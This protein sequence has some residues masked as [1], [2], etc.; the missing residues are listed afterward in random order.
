M[1]DL[2]EE[3]YNDELFEE[4]D[5]SK[6]EDIDVSY[7]QNRDITE[8]CL[9]KTSTT[10][11]GVEVCS[12]CG[13]EIYKELSLEPEWRYYGDNDS[14]HSSDPSR[15]HIR[16]NDDK[17]IYQDI[18]AYNFPPDIATEINDNYKLVTSGQ[19]RRGNYRK[20]IIFAAAFNVYKDRNIAQDPEE[21]REKF[22]ITKKEAS[23]GLN[24]YNLNNKNRKKP[25]YI[26]P[27]SF[28]PRIMEKFKA[29]DNHIASVTDLYNKIYNRSKLL[30]RS[31][32]QSVIAG[33]VFYYIRLIGATIPCSKFSKIVNLSDIT[34]NKISRTVSEILKTTNTVSLN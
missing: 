11:G 24:Y 28:I 29:G 30:N 7:Y 9:H 6:L 25:V 15:C 21:L 23:R 1:A 22:K 10:E 34:I 27:I 2:D 12:E 5:Y 18:E 33:L 14:K 16:K 19:I 17:N 26:S 13:M 20:A 32:P 4:E 8:I 3:E 31:N